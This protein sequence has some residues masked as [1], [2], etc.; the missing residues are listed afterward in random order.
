M[1]TE[2]RL[3]VELHTFPG[4][5][6]FLHFLIPH[7]L[8]LFFVFSFLAFLVYILAIFCY[9][10]HLITAL[11][12]FICAFIIIILKSILFMISIVLHDQF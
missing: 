4:I 12:L 8:A 3:K 5:N 6:I 11:K 2:Y 10:L 9:L 1:K 7:L